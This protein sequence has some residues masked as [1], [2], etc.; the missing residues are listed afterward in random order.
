MRSSER[1]A[2]G[3]IWTLL[4]ACAVLLCAPGLL[5]TFLVARALGAGLDRPQLWAFGATASLALCAVCAAT[6][7]SFWRGF[8]RYALASLATAWGV[9]LAW[10]GFRIRAAAELWSA[11][12]P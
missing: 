8:G 4:L 10:W 11:L 6:S 12:F 1:T 3:T 9:G 7:R 5:A 2:D